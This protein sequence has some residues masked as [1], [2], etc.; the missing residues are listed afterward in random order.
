MYFIYIFIMKS[1][2]KSLRNCLKKIGI[3]CPI[4]VV[5]FTLLSNLATNYI[6]KRT[7]HTLLFCDYMDRAS[8][9]VM[10]GKSN[11]KFWIFLC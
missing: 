5:T 2:D 1:I 4:H 7:G 9:S 8:D 10:I 11:I 6:Q 3:Y